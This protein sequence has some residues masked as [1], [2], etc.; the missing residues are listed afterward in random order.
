MTNENARKRAGGRGAGQR[1]ESLPAAIARRI[2]ERILGGEFG[3]G[4][5]LPNEAEWGRKFGAS[6]T[7]VRE[8]IRALAAKGMITSR[9]KVG[10]RVE[11]KSRWNLLDRDVLSWHRSAVDRKAF[12]ASTQEFRRLVE[13]GIAELAALKRSANQLEQ[14]VAAFQAMQRAKF[15]EETVSSDVNFHETL[16]ACTNNE[17]LT[18]LGILIAETLAELFDF[19]SSRNPRYKQALKLHENIV[20]AVAAEDAAAARKAMLALIKDTDSVITAALR[21][22]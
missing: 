12:L 3:P 17:L 14:L 5:L 15:H 13:P 16:L 2:G 1:P 20:R 19:T 21:R 22:K 18:P 9:P 4:S 8:A 10:S 11:P 7:A 6:R